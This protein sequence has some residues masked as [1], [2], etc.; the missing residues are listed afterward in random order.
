M[1][2]VPGEPGYQ[3]CRVI[4][5]RGPSQSKRVDVLGVLGMLNKCP[6]GW[7][8]RRGEVVLGETLVS[9]M[10]Q[11][12]LPSPIPTVFIYLEKQVGGEGCGSGEHQV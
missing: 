10:G 8:W 3:G 9:S 7:S 4:S 1:S 6:E 12:P 2:S 5:P 11:S